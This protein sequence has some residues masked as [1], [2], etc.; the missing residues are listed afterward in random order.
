MSSD[1]QIG[2][3]DNDT[4]ST[5][6]ERDTQKQEETQTSQQNAA[7]RCISILRSNPLYS[8]VS[9][10]FHWRE[11]LRSGLLFGIFNFVFLLITWGGYS[12]VT[13]VSY[14]FLALIAVCFSYVNFVVLKAKWISGKAA[15][16]P[17]QERFKTTNFHVSKESAEQHLNTV[18]ELTNIVIDSWRE[19]LYCTNVILSLQAAAICYA[20]ATVGGWFAGTTLLYLVILGFFVWPR[21]Y[22]EKQKEID[23]AYALGLTH[24]NNYYQLALSKIPPGVTA[25]LPFLKPKKT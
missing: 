24:L 3:L 16:N 18:L 20:T 4:I 7:N 21:L 8:D 2:D 9:N 25:K 6:T 17:F 10:V 12:V 13:L 19:I 23:A 14:L 22:E 5:S 11:P 15:E 1:A